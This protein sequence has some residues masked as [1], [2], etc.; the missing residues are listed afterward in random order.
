MSA[1][2][3]AVLAPAKH[4]STP[5]ESYPT[6]AVKRSIRGDCLA[7]RNH[8]LAGSGREWTLYFD[9][10]ELRDAAHGYVTAWIDLD[11]AVPPGWWHCCGQSLDGSRLNHPD[12]IPAPPCWRPEPQT[13]SSPAGTIVEAT[14]CRIA[15]TPA[16]TTAVEAAVGQ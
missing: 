15:E 14:R 12:A 11:P 4:R 2:R 10:G 6:L 9:D 8:N 13:A 1:R 7:I 16:G 3:S 5:A